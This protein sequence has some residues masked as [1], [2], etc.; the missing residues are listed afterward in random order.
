MTETFN[1]Y[2]NGI[3]DPRRAERFIVSKTKSGRTILARKPVDSPRTEF[4]GSQKSMRKIVRQAV[5]YAEFACDQPIY[6]V[7]ALGTS[8]TP[9][10]LAVADYLKKPKVLDID[11]R[12]WSEGAGQKIHI[13][14]RD[15]FMVLHVRLVI[16][17]VDCVL[18][19]GEA[20][21]SETDS[22][23]WTYTTRT[24]V[25]REPGLSLAAYAYDLPGNVGEYE[26]E[27]R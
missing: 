26:V 13:Q 12:D 5:T 14:A 25:A 9:Y 22:L 23:V 3:T 10:L 8:N 15:D 4:T 19:E 18:E 1:S 2:T 24:Y 6:Q 11:L 20:V 16:R 27:L 17:E 21:Q 7:K